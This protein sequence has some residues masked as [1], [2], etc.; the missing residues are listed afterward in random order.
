MFM[1]KILLLVLVMICACHSIQKLTTENGSV[2]IKKTMSNHDSTMIIGSINELSTGDHL[3]L[4]DI[5]FGDQRFPCDTNGNFTIQLIPGT[6]T[7]E[8]R[9]MNFKNFK[10]VLVA[11]K[12]EVINLTYYLAAFKTNTPYYFIH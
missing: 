9:A 6:Y 11:K 12:G 1:R 8:A 10:H 3:K 2:L 4:S 5:W 7:I